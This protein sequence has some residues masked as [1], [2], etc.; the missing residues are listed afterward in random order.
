M[1]APQ[2]DN[3]QIHLVTP[4]KDIPKRPQVKGKFF[5]VGD[6][7]L[8]I[9]GVTYGTFR[10]DKSGNEFHNPEVVKKDFAHMA[11]VGI[12]VV[13]VYTPPPTWLLDIALQKGLYVMVGLPWEQ[14]VTFLD[15]RKTVRSIKRRVRTMIRKLSGHS[16]ILCYVIGNEIPASIVRWHGRI[17]IERFLKRLYAI[18][19]MEDPEG[20]VTYVNFP[21]TEYLQLSFLDFQCFNVYLEEQER[22]ESYLNRLQNIAGDLPLVMGEIGLDSRRNGEEKQAEVLDWQIR[23]AF[24]LGCAGAFVYAWTDE[25]HR[26]GYDIED[27]DFGLTDRNRHPKKALQSVQRAF[28][29]VP[30]PPDVAWPRISVVVCSYNGSNTIRN[31][32]E[33][34]LKLDYPDFEVIVVNDGSTDE[35]ATITREY[36]FRLIN[37]ENRGLSS[38]RNTGLEAAT[39]EIV[40][41]M[42]DDAFPDQDWLKY[43]AATFMAY[44]CAGV[45]GPNIAPSND[46]KIADCIANAPGGPTHVLVCDLEAEHIPGCNM[47]FRRDCLKSIKGFDPQFRAAGDDV[48]VCWRIQQCGWWLAF[49][50]AAMVWHHRRNSIRTYWKQ[51]IGYGKAEALLERKW[52]QKYNSIGHTSWAGRI[53]GNG[54]TKSVGWKKWRIYY[55]SCGCA[56]FQSLYGHSPTFLQALPLMPEWYKVNISLL[57]LSLLG[58][59][60][61]PLLLAIPLLVITAGIPL[62]NVIK[63]M[64]EASFTSRPLSGLDRLKLRV[65]TGLLHIIQPMARLCGRL[66]HGLTLWRRRGASHFALPLPQ[67]YQIWSENWQAPEKW[68]QFIKTAIARLGAIIKQG[69]DFDHWDLEVRGGLCGSAR[70]LMAIEEHGGGKQLVRFY[71]WPIVFPVGLA[72]IL[73]LAFLSFLALSDQVWLVASLLGIVTVGLAIHVFQ[74]CAV[75]TAAFRQVMRTI[76]ELKDEAVEIEKDFVFRKKVREG[77]V[78]TSFDRRK[79]TN[80]YFNVPERRGS[81]DRRNGVIFTDFDRRQNNNKHYNGPER[82]SGTERRNSLAITASQAVR[83]I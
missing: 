32:F 60:W 66:R 9:R 57:V 44:D 49:A 18:A 20:L 13:R 45:G 30:F 11:A 64:V 63:S 35:T 6:E 39:G 37:T 48:D 74:D 1:Q 31:C 42:D 14:H 2:S 75:A 10:P 16:A 73:L 15:Q 4:G 81:I 52:P 8:W 41:Y 53:Y 33:G 54:L 38:A 82:R 22:L 79:N 56:P 77:L 3:Q 55:G 70:L 68:L 59:F 29:E 34:L 12:N 71:T 23:T 51:Q 43:L 67:K 40:A 7:K 65:L 83:R 50:P 69:D 21:T 80:P 5:Y 72:L 78:Y 47:A 17:K 62:I 46:G 76:G 27:W 25:W 58:L 24:R 36:G 19:K 28:A 26:G 61:K